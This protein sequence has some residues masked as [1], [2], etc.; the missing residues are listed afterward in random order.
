MYVGG[1]TPQTTCNWALPS[2]RQELLYS[3]HELGAHSPPVIIWKVSRWEQES[4]VVQ[5]TTSY[6]DINRRDPSMQK[7]LWGLLY[8]MTHVRMKKCEWDHFQIRIRTY[9]RM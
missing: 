8:A 7:E 9:V 4:C 6:V 3:K 2:H 5:L 1:E